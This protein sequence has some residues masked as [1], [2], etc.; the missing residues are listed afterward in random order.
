MGSYLT[1]VNDT[2]DIFF[3]IYGPDTLA[4]TLG[5]ESIMKKL[6]PIN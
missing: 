2:D 4:L 6:S 3:A 1:I 5:L